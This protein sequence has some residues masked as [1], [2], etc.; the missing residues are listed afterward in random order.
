[1]VCS[2]V[3]FH[4]IA[5]Y[6]TWKEQQH[7]KNNCKPEKQITEKRERKNANTNSRLDG[8]NIL[9]SIL[10]SCEFPNT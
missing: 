2:Y 5:A 9:L 4:T 6:Q 3:T 1:M 8:K 10:L 7:D